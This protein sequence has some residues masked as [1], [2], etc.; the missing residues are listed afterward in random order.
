MIVLKDL[1]K[2]KL[3]KP[4][5]ATIGTFD[6]VH[7]G[8]QKILKS[9]ISNSKQSSLKSVLITFDPHPRK[10]LDPNSKIELINTIDEKVDV[11]KK[12]GLDYLVIHEFSKN[13]S[14]IDAEDF[15]KILIDKLNIKKIIVGYDHRFGKNRSADIND[16]K[17][18]GIKYGFEVIEISA[19]DIEEIKI[20]STKIR[21]SL[22]NGKI[23]ICRKYTGFN[24]KLSGN[25]V[26]GMSRGNKMGFPT[27][28][29]QVID[30][31]KINLNNLFPYRDLITSIKVF[32]F[33]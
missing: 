20:S 28:N 6:G 8:H 18:F 5:I 15:V 7:L 25:V 12:L 24:F 21:S 33:E 17:E 31:N 22:Q 4:S 30:K 27:A 2:V 10:I 1:F 13:F 19:F 26:R 23:E 29:I 16:L 9:L 11:L 32:P 14:N 3:D